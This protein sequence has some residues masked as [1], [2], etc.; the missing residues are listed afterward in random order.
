[1]SISIVHKGT[2]K[3]NSFIKLYCTSLRNTASYYRQNH[4][5]AP[6]NLTLLYLLG[7]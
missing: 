3:S 4:A 5:I 2:D 6:E 7:N 1:V